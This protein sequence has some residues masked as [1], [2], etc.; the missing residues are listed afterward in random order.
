MFLV[1]EHVE[2]RDDP[3]VTERRTVRRRPPARRTAAEGLCVG[4]Q[5][6]QRTR[7][8]RSD[9][10]S[11]R[12]LQG[13]LHRHRRQSGAAVRQ[14]ARTRGRPSTGAGARRTGGNV[15]TADEDVLR[16]L[17][18]RLSSRPESEIPRE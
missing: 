13:A 11:S 12:T 7:T 3:G 8:P 14:P 10:P 5:S 17:D 6:V 15:Q 1:L 18:S 4:T 2:Q 16:A 9:D